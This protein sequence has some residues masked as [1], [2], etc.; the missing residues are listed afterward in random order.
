MKRLEKAAFW[1][2]EHFDACYGERQKREVAR[3][4]AAKRPDADV[5]KRQREVILDCR[6]KVLDRA[7][8]LL[9]GMSDKGRV[10]LLAYV[11]AQKRTMW[12]RFAKSDQWFYRLP[13]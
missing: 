13:R 9:R 6:Q 4:R 10:A 2:N 11:E 3:L 7:D 5:L 1:Y 8:V 12:S